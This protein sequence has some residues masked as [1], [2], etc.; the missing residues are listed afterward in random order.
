LTMAVSGGGCRRREEDAS[1]TPHFV[2][3]ALGI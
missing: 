2:I 3:E 1:G